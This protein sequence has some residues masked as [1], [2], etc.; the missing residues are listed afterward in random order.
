MEEK[1]IELANAYEVL[2]DEEKRK[3]Y[4]EG[5]YD[6][7]FQVGVWTYYDEKG[8]KN[9]EETYFSEPIYQKGQ[10]AETKEY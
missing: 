10:I 2:S 1:F 8:K 9:L 6:D 5:N 3:E 7:G 4:D